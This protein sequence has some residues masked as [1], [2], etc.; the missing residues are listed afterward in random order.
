M[1]VTMLYVEGK[2]DK[3]LL[4]PI[5]GGHLA[6]DRK[7]SKDDLHHLVRR[8]RADGRSV[9]YIRDRDF[10]FEPVGGGLNQPDPDKTID[11]VVHGYRW[12]RTDIECYLLEPQLVAAATGVDPAAVQTALVNAAAALRDYE[13]ARWT[14]AQSK[15]QLP[16]KGI[17]QTRP[18]TLHA[19]YEIPA[20]LS[21]PESWNWIRTVA[22]DFLS[23]ANSALDEPDLQNRY[24]SYRAKLNHAHWLDV[25]MWYSGKDLLAQMTALRNQLHCPQPADFCQKMTTWI[26]QYSAQAEGLLPEWV[27]LRRILTT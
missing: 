3:A 15:F 24:Q 7:G 23:R 10:D 1:P 25:L 19:Q 27:E 18:L 16:G 9:C 17:I 14:V 13:A 22:S 5:L 4:N 8:E 11:Q 12:K 20:N 2:L 21:E 6:I 26:Q